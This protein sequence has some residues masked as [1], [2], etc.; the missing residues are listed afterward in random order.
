[1]RHLAR[2]PAQTGAWR[3]FF[4]RLLPEKHGVPALVQ[5]LKKTTIQMAGRSTVH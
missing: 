5:M 2:P 4:F 1:M 3:R